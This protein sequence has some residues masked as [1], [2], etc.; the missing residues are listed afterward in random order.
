M[1]IAYKQVHLAT[2][3]VSIKC[4]YK[5]E[6]QRAEPVSL[7]FQSALRKRNTESSIHYVEKISHEVHFD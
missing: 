2:V 1:K 3:F 4:L 5:L 7:T 6:A